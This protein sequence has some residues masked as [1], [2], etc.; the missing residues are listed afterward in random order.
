MFFS[1]MKKLSTW[2]EKQLRHALVEGDGGQPILQ[3]APT[4]RQLLAFDAVAV[5]AA[6]DE[7]GF[8]FEANAGVRG[9]TFPPKAGS[10]PVGEVQNLPACKKAYKF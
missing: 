9:V 7:V 4:P 5:A 6:K 8:V 2:C 1:E 10:D 3:K